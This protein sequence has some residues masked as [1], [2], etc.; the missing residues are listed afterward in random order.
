MNAL[1][2][3]GHGMNTQGQPFCVTSSPPVVFFYLLLASP[4]VRPMDRTAPSIAEVRVKRKR[5]QDR[6]EKAIV[7][8]LKGI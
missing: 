5:M 6:G 7:V 2:Q 1:T 8:D 4:L 3:T